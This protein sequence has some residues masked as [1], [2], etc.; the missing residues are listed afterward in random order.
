MTR[1]SSLISALMLTAIFGLSI[2]VA[3]EKFEEDKEEVLQPPNL[4][5]QGNIA[6][7]RYL[8][9]GGNKSNHKDSEPAL[10]VARS[11]EDFSKAISLISSRPPELT[12]FDPKEE[13]LVFV[14]LGEKNTSGY[15]I[16]INEVY[17]FGKDNQPTDTIVVEAVFYSPHPYRQQKNQRSSPWTAVKIKRKDLPQNVQCIKFNLL[18]KGTV[19]SYK[20][21]SIPK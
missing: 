4:K 11:K 1:K 17:L 16:K 7:S 10:V 13:I 9:V 21:A 14:F 15:F 2:V 20:E 18:L 5:L 12:N 3:Q 6:F 8:K 19:Y